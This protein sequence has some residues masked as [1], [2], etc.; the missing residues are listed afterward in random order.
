MHTSEKCVVQSG[1]WVGNRVEDLLG[2]AEMADTGVDEFG[3]EQSVLVEAMDD[4]AGV[5]LGEVK[6]V[7]FR[8]VRDGREG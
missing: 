7:F 1:V 2:D 3:R 6:W 5:D 4:E 8:G